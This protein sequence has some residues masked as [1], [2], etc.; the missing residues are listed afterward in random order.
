MAAILPE[1]V[2]QFG[3]GKFLRGF[4]DLFLHQ[5]NENGQN[6]GRVVVV[7]STA[8]APIRWPA[9]A[10]A[11]MSWCAAWKTARSSTVSRSRPASASPWRRRATGT[12]SWHWP[13]L[14]NCI[15][16]LEHS[17]VGYTLDPNDG[18]NRRPPASFP[19]KLTAVLHE[20]FQA[21]SRA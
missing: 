13:A 16:P 9:R 8:A 10:A 5:A 14:P 19:A 15:C 3:S 2:L 6:V 1:T 18:P 7:Q 11:I 21:D 17:Q 12:A 20:H 4:A